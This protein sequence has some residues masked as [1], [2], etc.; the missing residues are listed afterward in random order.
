MAIVQVVACGNE[1]HVYAADDPSAVVVHT[2]AIGANLD[3]EL[4]RMTE[5]RWYAVRTSG[6]LDGFTATDHRADR[7]DCAT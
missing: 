7:A 2:V 6:R 3:A 4:F 5:Q 1:V